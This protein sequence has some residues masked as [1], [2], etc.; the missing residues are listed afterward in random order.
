[1]LIVVAATLSGISN[2]I[3]KQNIIPDTETPWNA[4]SQEVTKE[5]EILNVILIFYTNQQVAS[6][7]VH[8][9]HFSC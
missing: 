7:R 4:H 5:Q 3:Y 8:R 1:M 6:L 2:T 9:V